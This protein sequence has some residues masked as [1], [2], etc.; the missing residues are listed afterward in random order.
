MIGIEVLSVFGLATLIAYILLHFWNLFHI[1]KI[2]KHLP[3]SESISLLK[4][5]ALVTK[6]HRKDYIPIIMSYVKEDAPLTKIW[7][8]GHLFILTKNAEFINKVYNSPETYNR[9]SIIYGMLSKKLSLLTLKGSQHE[10]RRKILNKA[11]DTKMLQKLPDIF[12][13]KSKLILSKL[14]A[15]VDCEEFDVMDYVGAYSLEAFGAQ[16]LNHQIDYFK[17]GIQ[18]AFARFVKFLSN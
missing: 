16:N 15:N 6:T 4:S 8:L 18:D 2:A 11:F 1:Y 12:D 13:D 9:P 17:S 10:K 14:D 5:I 7:C 3:G